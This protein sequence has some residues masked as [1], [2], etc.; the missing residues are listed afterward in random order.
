M[1]MCDKFMKLHGKSNDYKVLYTNVASLYL[2]P[3]HD[4]SNMVLCVCLEHPLRQGATSY[5]HIVLQLPRDAPMEAE[6]ALSEA[7]C[8]YIYIYIYTYI[9]IH[10][11]TYTY[12]Y[13]GRALGGRV[14]AALRRQARQ[15]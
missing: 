12:T 4:G 13:T 14:H 1:E 10:I 3:K 8:T 15:V 7:E 2:L 6:V 5:P 11:H 9:H